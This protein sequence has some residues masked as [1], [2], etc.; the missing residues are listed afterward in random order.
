MEPPKT[1][2]ELIYRWRYGLFLVVGAT[3]ALSALGIWADL[4]IVSGG[5]R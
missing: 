2:T 4:V 5:C 1:L 3:M